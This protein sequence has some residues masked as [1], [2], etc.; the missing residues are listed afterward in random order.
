M[1]NIISI[2][3]ELTRIDPGL[4]RADVIVKNAPTD[5]FGAAFDLLISG[6]DW[7]LKSYEAG[8]LFRISGTP[9]LMLAVEKGAVGGS[10]AVAVTGAAAGGKAVVFKAV[11]SHRIVTGLSL[12]R[13]VNLESGDGTLISFYINA[14]EASSLKFGFANNILSAL[15]EGKRV[16]LKD[17]VWT[18]SEM[19]GE[20]V[21]LNG[22]INNGSGSLSVQGGSQVAGLQLAG[23]GGTQV[24]ETTL[25]QTSLF[26]SLDSD[27]LGLLWWE[28]PVFQVYLFLG[29]ALAVMFLVIFALVLAKKIKFN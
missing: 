15:R 18:G 12:K 5:T 8:E 23:S 22:S 26:G 9:P 13:G 7:S 24:A 29:I 10:G 28:D 16:D 11:G 6:G 4:I 3:F 2:K 20:P 17:A 25:V 14:S 27:S 19:K 1:E 21:S